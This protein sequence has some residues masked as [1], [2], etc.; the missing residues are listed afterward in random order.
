MKR[1]FIFVVHRRANCRAGLGSL[2][3]DPNLLVVGPDEAGH[4]TVTTGS[5]TYLASCFSTSRAIST[6]F[7]PCAVSSSISGVEILLSG[8]TGTESRV[9]GCAGR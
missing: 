8:R 4:D 9:P 5:R 6:E 1:P 3:D 7:L 2:D